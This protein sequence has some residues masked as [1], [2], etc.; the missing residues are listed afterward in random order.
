MR[1]FA[2]KCANI[3]ARILPISFWEFTE[4]ASAYFAGKGSGSDSVTEE[5]KVAVSI[6]K[7]KDDLVLFDVGANKGEWSAQM[8]NVLGPKVV[9]VY[10]FEPS[11]R[12]GE[13]L[14][15][16]FS[17]KRV[18]LVPCAVSDHE[19]RMDLFSDVPGSGMASLYKRRLDHAHVSLKEVT[20]ISAIT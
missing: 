9:K 16:H 14:Q 17:D 8:L 6:V 13:F 11:P 2:K 19:G 3:I 12:N 20:S 10:Q 4:Y 15:K 7:G 1:T 5:T 18:S